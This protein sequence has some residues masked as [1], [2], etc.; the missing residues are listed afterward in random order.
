MFDGNQYA[1]Q[2]LINYEAEQDG[3]SF[4]MDLICDYQPNLL[5][6]VQQSNIIDVFKL[7]EFHDTVCI[8]EYINNMKIYFKE[9]NF[10]AKQVD[11]LQ[12]I[13]DQLQRNPWFTTVAKN[14]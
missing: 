13:Q 12:L 11:I 4:M 3:I 1:N 6:S 7:P 8:W 10:T 5:A 2:S 9:I 14:L